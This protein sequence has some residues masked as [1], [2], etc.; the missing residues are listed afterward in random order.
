M[1]RPKMA[2]ETEIATYDALFDDL[3][4]HHF[5]KFVVIRG[6]SFLGAF[7][8]FENAANA[9]VQ[10][11]GAGPFL[12]R[13]VGAAPASLPASVLYRPAVTFAA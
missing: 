2:L 11:F 6:D 1:E 12:I 4:K 13:Q 8:N 7:D 9:A 5:A 10:A 3:V